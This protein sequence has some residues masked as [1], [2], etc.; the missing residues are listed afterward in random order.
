MSTLTLLS[1]ASLAVHDRTPPRLSS[2]PGRSDT[3][4]RTP[5]R[6]QPFPPPSLTLTIS[7][8]DSTDICTRAT[9]R[10]RALECSKYE[11]MMM[12]AGY[13]SF[14]PRDQHSARS[15]AQAPPHSPTLLPLRV[16]L[17]VAVFVGVCVV[18]VSK[19]KRTRRRLEGRRGG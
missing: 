18:C 16:L 12:A 17:L 15:T 11:S 19:E 1:D 4:P 3:H 10:T 8:G 2:S 5:T 7:S 14:L 6:Y 9:G 13:C